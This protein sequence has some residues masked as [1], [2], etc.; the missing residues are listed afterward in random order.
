MLS[1]KL[2]L[3]YPSPPQGGWTQGISTANTFNSAKVVKSTHTSPRRDQDRPVEPH[4][5][6][7]FKTDI[8]AMMRDVIK[9][10]F[11]WALVGS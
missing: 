3:I 9:I 6:A 4:D 11:D 8:A 10:L 1:L 5:L 7:A 2:H